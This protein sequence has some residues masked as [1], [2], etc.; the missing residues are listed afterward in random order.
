MKKHSCLIVMVLQILLIFAACDNAEPTADKGNRN[1]VIW[2]IEPQYKYADPFSCGAAAVETFEGEILF[3]DKLNRQL[4][5][6]KF[7][8]ISHDYFDVPSF[9]YGIASV[10]IGE[11]ERIKYTRSGTMLY[12]EGFSEHITDEAWLHTGEYLY[13]VKEKGSEMMGYMNNQELW[14]I[15]PIYGFA[16]AYSDGYSF[17]A[18]GHKNDYYLVDEF[19]KITQT[20]SLMA[21]LSE[22]LD[23]IL[24]TEIISVF[25]SKYYYS[26]VNIDGKAV[27][28]GPFTEALPFSEG[29]AGVK[30]NGL[31]GY[32]DS[33]GKTVV[34]PE[35]EEAGQF[36]EGFTKVKLDGLW[37][38]IDKQ[39][40]I[41]VEP[42]YYEA[43]DFSE[44]RAYVYKSEYQSK[45]IDTSGIS[46]TKYMPTAYFS[47]FENDLSVAANNRNMCGIFD[48]T[49][50][51][52]VPQN[53]DF[54]Y[55][56]DTY[57]VLEKN[58]LYEIYLYENDSIIKAKYDFYEIASDNTIV[59]YD[60]KERCWMLDIERGEV[61]PEAYA[62]L[63]EYSEGLFRACETADG[64]W[65]FADAEGKWVIQPQFEEVNQFNE[66]LAPVKKDGKWGYIA[67]PLIYSKWESQEV[68][69]GEILGLFKASDIERMVKV[70]DALEPIAEVINQIMGTAYVPEDIWSALDL[71]SKG[72]TDGNELLTR[73]KA[74]VIAGAAAS[75]CGEY[76][77]CLLAF[78]ED[79]TEVD[80]EM[81]PYVS[82]AASFGLF[83][84]DEPGF[85]QPKSEVAMEEMYSMVVRLFETCVYLRSI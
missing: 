69:R 76:V 9:R 62:G 15:P 41:V 67:N 45:I 82:Y 49:G 77:F 65:G 5:D 34:E 73:E 25:E 6:T 70:A 1:D 59:L 44:N 36:C 14:Y 61:L 84:L 60:T 80:E 78:L 28:E 72:I 42:Q 32:I 75:Y 2:A 74:S 4:F 26:Y 10:V 64:L 47:P 35:F 63:L 56:H 71:T 79:E 19:G 27:I 29:L 23:T 37:G 13:P 33:T 53:Y 68:A 52:V 46:L 66:G 12:G 18:D 85:F 30:I 83:D 24:R 22:G 3:I 58:G 17:A 81:L 57:A 11:D 55:I 20:P 31:W 7:T 8:D 48:K 40:E 54:I 51:L 16:Q 39:G 50:R 38:Y 43:S 21:H